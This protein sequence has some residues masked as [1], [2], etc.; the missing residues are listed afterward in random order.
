MISKDCTPFESISGYEEK[1]LNILC[2]YFEETA[3]GGNDDD[4]KI[5]SLQTMLFP[6]EGGKTTVQT[7]WWAGRYIGMA[8]IGVP[9]GKENEKYHHIE[10]SIRPRFGER[11]LL[12]ILEG[13]NP[14]IVVKKT[15]NSIRIIPAIKGTFVCFFKV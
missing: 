12:A 13:I 1:A 9:Y 5:V 4:H 10:I 6:Y 7:R 11:F 3:E 2:E 14:A 8:N 15:L